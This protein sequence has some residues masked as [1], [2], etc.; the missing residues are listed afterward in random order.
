MALIF[1]VD[2]K[3]RARPKIRCDACG[4]IIQNYADGV[5]V[6]DTAEVKPGTVIEPIFHC[7][8][9]EEEAE[10]TRGSRH[11]MPIDH[12]MLYVFNNI[13]LTPSALENAGRSLKEL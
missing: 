5:A 12:F 9:C 10:K 2:E 8:H 7:N 3:G 11:T 1:Q 4:G 6:T 13:Q